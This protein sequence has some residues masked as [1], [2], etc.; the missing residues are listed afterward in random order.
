MQDVAPEST[1]SLEEMQTIAESLL[2]NAGALITTETEFLQADSPNAVTVRKLVFS[3]PSTDRVF[4]V[5]YHVQEGTISNITENGRL[6][7]NTLSLEQFVEW[8]TE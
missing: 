6:Y 1:L 5:D 3:T 2:Y 7:P 8:A 4:T